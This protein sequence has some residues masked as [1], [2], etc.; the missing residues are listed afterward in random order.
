[1]KHFTFLLLFILC[2]N[3]LSGQ[4]LLNKISKEVC[5]CLETAK[6]E[7]SDFEALVISC[8]EKSMI[9]HN[10]ELIKEYGD[11]FSDVN[12]NVAYEFGI[13]LGKILVKDC[14][15]FVD[16]IV[17]QNKNTINDADTLYKISQEKF[18]ENLFDESIDYL[19]KAI[20]L[21]NDNAEYYNLRGL[22]FFNKE[23][24]YEAISDF[25]KV[26]DLQPTNNITY[27]NIAHSKYNLDDINGAMKAINSSIEYDSSY[28][29][30]LNFKGLIFSNLAE[31]DSS[32][33]YFQKAYN[34]DSTDYIFVFNLGYG[35]YKLQDYKKALAIFQKSY[36]IDSTNID[37]LS[38]MG[39]CY[40]ELEDYDK[41][42]E[43][44]SRIITR[45][46]GLN[47]IAFY[48]RGYSYYEKNEFLKALS[49]FNDAYKLDSSDVDV[50]YRLAKTYDALD[51]DIEARKYYNIILKTDPKNANYYDS[52]AAFY[53]KIKEYD[54]ALSDYQFSLN[55]Y[56]DD[57]I[58]YQLMGKIYLLQNKKDSANESF[59]KSVD[60]GCEDSKALIKN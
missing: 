45:T 42:I 28:C 60:L 5:G 49:D 33:V 47:Y 14:N 15:V 30:A 44:Q 4:K 18:N 22:S 11:S 9:K 35:Y 20:V 50:P 21:K 38:Y 10:A 24:Y 48:N 53:T 32:I 17:S 13:E 29:R 12:S 25:L 55:L 8:I 37:L 26:L 16:Y 43:F 1:M 19:N 54:L 6:T 46:E 27:Y 23:M 56:P 40:S 59:K 58:N 7:N 51:N 34:C 3:P 41:A 39:N 36:S 31:T 57:C 52:R 2:F